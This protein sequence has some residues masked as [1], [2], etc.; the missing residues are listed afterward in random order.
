MSEY[1]LGI[2]SFVVQII[3]I[4]ITIR[5]TIAFRKKKKSAIFAIGA[6]IMFVDNFIA[7]QLIMGG[8]PSFMVGLVLSPILGVIASGITLCICN[9]I[10]K[11][12]K[13]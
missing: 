10:C 4:V 3:G 9:Y 12:F 11:K 5:L 6:A 7:Q 8:G 1:D 2:L 13:L